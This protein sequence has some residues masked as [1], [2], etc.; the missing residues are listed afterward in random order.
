MELA[1]TIARI[2]NSVS[3][4]FF[5]DDL[6]QQQFHFESFKF[7]E[8]AEQQLGALAGF[9]FSNKD[10]VDLRRLYITK[11]ERRIIPGSSRCGIYFILNAK[12]GT[13]SAHA[14]SLALCASGVC[15]PVPRASQIMLA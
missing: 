15:I 11:I 14:T 9:F 10:F 3:F 6:H 1:T 5:F 2:Y 12:A 7:Q 13:A 8:Q 4:F